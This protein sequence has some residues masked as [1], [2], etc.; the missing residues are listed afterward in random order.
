MTSQFEQNIALLKKK[1]APCSSAEQKYELLIRLGKEAPLMAPESKTP[2]RLVPGCQSTMFLKTTK[3]EGKLFFE[4]DSDAL[5]SAGLGQILCLAFSGLSPEEIL[6][7]PTT[8]LD[9]L[10]IPGSLTPSRV[11]GLYQIHL[12]MK[13]AALKIL[14]GV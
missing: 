12:K 10:G 7:A 4:T 2:D 8:F 3:K 13:Q 6:T 11:N 14:T 1:F 9:E 5:I